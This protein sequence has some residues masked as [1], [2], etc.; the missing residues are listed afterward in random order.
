MQEV[1]ARAVA[2]R[3]DGVVVISPHSPRRHGAFGLWHGEQLRGSLAAFGAAGSEFEL[4]IDVELRSRVAAECKAEGCATWA[5][6]EA[7]LDHGAVVPL[8]FLVAA[9][10]KGPT[11]VISLNHPGEGG[12]TGLGRAIR[13]AARA[14]SRRVVVIASGD[15]SHR[16]LPGAPCGF[17]PRA[18]DFDRELID[19]LRR[20]EYRKLERIEPGLQDL[21]AE[22]AL[23]STLV[24]VAAGDWSSTGHRVLSYEGPF[25]VGYGVAV[26]LDQSTTDVEI[27]PETAKEE[28][29]EHPGRELPGI[30]RRSIEAA[31][32]G[33][34][35]TPPSGREGYLGAQRAVFVTLRDGDGELRGCVGSLWP[36]MRSMAEE[37]WAMARDAAFRDARFPRVRS[38]ELD[39]LRVEV[40]VLQPSEPV[41]TAADLDPDVYGVMVRTGDGRRGVLLPGIPEIRTADQQLEIARRKG[42]IRPEEPVQLERFRIEKFEEQSAP[43]KR[44]S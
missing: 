19:L 22:D 5:I 4:P 29:A 10:W 23:D 3:P 24:A 2:L 39:G 37:T 1:A 6:R 18:G 7:E 41:A 16:L 25:G 34:S 30:A 17:E 26:L 42:G 31:L 36:R 33:E 44:S 9:G 8:W 13:G 12:L 43:G 27:H 35:E 40:S 32:N 20:G 38:E 28:K 11:L 21:A 15:M 14:L